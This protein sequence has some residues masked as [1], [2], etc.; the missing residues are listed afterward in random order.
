[1]PEGEQITPAGNGA[2]EAAPKPGDG[3]VDIK[4]LQ[5]Q[6]DEQQQR[7]KELTDSE[8]HWASQAMAA[9]NGGKLAAKPK[10]EDDLDEDLIDGLVDEDEKGGAEDTPEALI[11]ALNKDGASA[12]RKR[13]FITAKEAQQIAAKAA[14]IATTR[15]VAKAVRQL[16]EDMEIEKT[17]GLGDAESEM[18]KE[19]SAALKDLTGGDRAKMQD[20]TLLK[21]AAEIAKARIS[22]KVAAA[23]KKTREEIDAQMGYVGGYG[24]DFDD[25]SGEEEVLSPLQERIR[26]KFNEDGGI[27]VTEEAYRKRAKDV[28]MKPMATMNARRAR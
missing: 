27:Q 8:R 24:A 3:G 2:G 26:R 6:I 23:P 28:R 16:I 14:S 22:A 10:P 15:G 17:Y 20:R 4:G 1:M 11:E 21:A 25:G 7:I 18:F 19:T 13:G 12:L 9:V 5:R